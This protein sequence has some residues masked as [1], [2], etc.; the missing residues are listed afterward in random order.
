MNYL[1]KL[2]KLALD[3]EIGD[4][5]LM[6]RFK[7]QREVVKM[8]G[9]DELGQPT[10]NGKKLLDMRIEKKLPFKKRSRVTKDEIEKKLKKKSEAG[11]MNVYAQLL[12]QAEL[13]DQSADLLSALAGTAVGAP[14]G[15]YLG[16]ALGSQYKGSSRERAAAIRSAQT[17]GTVL[18]GLLGG[19]LGYGISNHFTAPQEPTVAEYSQII[20][21][22]SMQQAMAEQQRAVAGRRFAQRGPLD[23]SGPGVYARYAAAQR[24]MLLAALLS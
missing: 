12:K 1:E 14:I 2:A 19:G 7:N 16:G 24:D 13:S 15:G 11:L 18:G 6:G 21:R 5:M 9:T 22:L 10:I 20:D 8:I 17:A 4:I 23:G 3:I